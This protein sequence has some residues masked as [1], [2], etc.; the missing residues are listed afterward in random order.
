MHKISHCKTFMVS[1]TRRILLCSDNL[2]LVA[3]HTECKFV[4]CNMQEIQ[5][6]MLIQHVG[7]NNVLGIATCWD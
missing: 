7:I 6:V 2:V 5:H 4:I 3:Q 1:E